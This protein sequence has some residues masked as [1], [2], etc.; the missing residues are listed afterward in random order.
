MNK[1]GGFFKNAFQKIEDSIAGSPPPIKNSN[2]NPYA[3]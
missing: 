1:I 3:R 2:N